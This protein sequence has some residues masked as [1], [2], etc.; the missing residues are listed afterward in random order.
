MGCYYGNTAWSWLC[1]VPF[2]V[3]LGLMVMMFL[4]ARRWCMGWMGARTFGK[5][6]AGGFQMENQASGRWKGMQGSMMQSCMEMM[7]RRMPEAMG[8]RGLHGAFERWS[9]DLQRK[10]LEL[11][12]QKGSAE[13]AEVAAALGVSEDVAISLLHRLA[14]KG[15]VRF[16]SVEKA[17]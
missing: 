10:I 2:L 9:D 16:G 6:M 1:L 17:K 15:K 8:D 5:R 13:P 3:M 11:L 4:M 14:L 7:G 12:E